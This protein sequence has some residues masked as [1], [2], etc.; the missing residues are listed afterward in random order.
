MDQTMVVDEE[1]AAGKQLID[2]LT[3]E[4]VSVEAAFWLGDATDNVWLLYIV[5]PLVTEEGVGQKAYRR[6]NEM[7]RKMPEIAPILSMRVRAIHPNDPIAQAVRKLVEQWPGNVPMRI[8]SS[9]SIGGKFV[10]AAYIYPRIL[11]AAA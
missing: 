6:I 7:R 2:G 1:I 10:D 4:G 11:S 5:T 8:W 3:T 9:R